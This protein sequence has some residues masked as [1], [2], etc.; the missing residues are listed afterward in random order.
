MGISI[1]AG[2]RIGNELGA[3]NP[4]KAKRA[5]LV[6]M[7]VVCKSD[8]LQSCYHCTNLVANTVIQVVCLQATKSYFGLIYTKDR[9]LVILIGFYISFCQNL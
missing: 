3:G 5:S 4:Q 9:Y 7:A 6:A 2:V 1:A 8:A